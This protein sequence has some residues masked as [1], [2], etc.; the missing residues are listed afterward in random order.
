MIRHRSLFYQLVVTGTAVIVVLGVLW[1]GCGAWFRQQR[2]KAARA[3]SLADNIRLQVLQARRTEKDFLLR[4][5][6]TA[7]FFESDFGTSN[8]QR[9]QNL[10]RHLA[11]VNGIARALVLSELL[12]DEA[13]MHRHLE[14]ATASYQTA[15][16]DMVGAYRILGYRNWGLVRQLR[17][18]A[19]Y[20]DSKAGPLDSPQIRI[21]LLELRRRETDYLLSGDDYRT[22]VRDALEGLAQLIDEHPVAGSGEAREELSEAIQLYEDAFENH[23]QLNERIGLSEQDGLR[24]QMRDA[25]Q[26][27]ERIAADV[28]ARSAADEKAAEQASNLSHFVILL[29][30]CLICALVFYFLARSIVKPLGVLKTEAQ[31]LGR[32]DLA[33]RATVSSG[34]E[35]GDLATAMNQMADSL[36]SAYDQQ[37]EM[38]KQR[39][40]AQRALSRS[41]TLYRSLVENIPLSL[42]QKDL[43]LRFMFGNQRFCDAI[44]RPEKEIVGKT[45]YDFFPKQLAAKY[46]TDDR[47]VMESEESIDVVEENVTADGTTRYVEVMKSPIRD[48]EGS[49]IGVQGL[50]WD[51]TD[52]VVAERSLNEANQ[53]LDS[54]INNIPVMMFV[55]S[56]VDLSY[57]RVNS[58]FEELVGQ[59]NAEL[60]GQTDFDIYPEEQAEIF[61][62]NDRE[63]LE[64]GRLLDIPEEPIQTK[65]HGLRVLHTKKIP[66]MDRTGRPSFLLGVSEDITVQ[67]E[68]ERAL[69]EAKEAAESASRAKSDFLANMSHEI[70]TPMNA[71]IG[72]T[73]LLLDT[74]LDPSQHDYVRMAHDSGESLLLLINDILD[75]SK[76]EAGKLDLEHAPFR[77]RDVV[78]DT[79]KSLAL[80][81]HRRRLELAFE[82]APDVHDNLIGDPVRLR[83]VIINLVGNAIKFTEDGEVVLEVTA[84]SEINADEQTECGVLNFVVRDTGIGIPKETLDRIFDA[85]EQADTSTTR[86]F[87]GTGLGLAISSRLVAMMG[88]HLHV[89][90]T[91][92]QGSEFRF[93]IPFDLSWD[94]EP[95]PPLPLAEEIAGM[96]VL[97]VDDNATNRRI[98]NEM[99]QVYEMQP[100]TAANAVEAMRL[101]TEASRAGEPFSLV[102]TDVHMPETDGFTLTQQI[103]DDTDLQDV[104][105]MVLTSG[106]RP[107]DRQRCARLGIST[108]LLKPVKQSEL[109]DSTAGK[110]WNTSDPPGSM[111]C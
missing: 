103:R 92:G 20:V 51:V 104:I 93:T 99:L 101:L 78:G 82:V 55:K 23:V 67:K 16:M 80:R 54:I 107:G 106:D 31:R 68:A 21:A 46:Q 63:V 73:E 3:R 27:I 69:H 72:M 18:A 30:G 2:D 5:S 34:S 100:E 66:I 111:P 105:V 70:R 17:D 90:S 102:L 62:T 37:Q 91:V 89:D 83:Q 85:F 14:T 35:I 87:G 25:A 49:L 40:E 39:E 61:R 28:A 32:G 15:F 43:N 7:Q 10:K 1:I 4:D 79:M 8:E 109:F 65:N 50:F 84:G 19:D 53:F 75:F 22:E 29:I 52:R 45:D 64:S 110:P 94:S 36:Q 81:A 38:S 6:R 97:V 98:L 86:R 59:S 11:A 71:V 24:G 44:G 88:G 56:A 58:T 76:I 108:Q 33:A 47:S 48:D 41:E 74:D 77:L 60:V 12:P 95:A 57:V 9:T 13:E 42:F 96:R 26:T